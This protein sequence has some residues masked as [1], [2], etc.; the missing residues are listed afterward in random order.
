MGNYGF[1]GLVMIDEI[2]NEGNIWI[3][4]IFS[5]LYFFMCAIISDVLVLI[6]FT[7]LVF[8]FINFTLSIILKIKEGNKIKKEILKEL[9]KMN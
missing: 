6:L 8:I 4:S 3:M 1:K 5:A 2:V 7:P 9:K